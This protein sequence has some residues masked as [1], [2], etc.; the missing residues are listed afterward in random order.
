MK[1]WLVEYKAASH[2]T[3]WIS[4]I[5]ATAMLAAV[6]RELSRI[7]IGVSWAEAQGDYADSVMAH[8]WMLVLIGVSFII[9]AFFLLVSKPERYSWVA[10]S[11]LLSFAT[12]VFY[13][14]E[15]LPQYSPATICE[16]DGRCFT[17]YHHS[18]ADWTALA[19]MGFVVFSFF[20][21]LVRAAVAGSKYR[22]R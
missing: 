19:G 12:V 10:I 18:S 2:R 9:R 3:R 13:L 5:G 6:A 20:R 14:W 15:M 1:G 8:V 17:I 7:Y 11:W 16:K 22:Y 21:V 4:L